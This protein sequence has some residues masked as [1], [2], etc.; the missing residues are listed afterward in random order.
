MI[1]ARKTQCSYTTMHDKT[2][3]VIGMI[4]P[5]IKLIT[6]QLVHGFKCIKLLLSA[7]KQFEKI[8]IICDL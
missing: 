7:L 1:E 4:V 2:F 6:T 3:M 8:K 5:W